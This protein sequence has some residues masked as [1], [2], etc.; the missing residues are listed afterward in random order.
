MIYPII[1]CGGTGARLWPLSRQ[2]HPK[3]FSKLIGDQ[4][5]FQQTCQRFARQGFANPVIVTNERF[6]FTVLDELAE[7]NIE[8]QDVILEAEA[9]NTAAAI[10]AAIFKIAEYDQ[11][12]QILIFASRSCDSRCG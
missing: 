1:L 12:A 11:N 6:R 2:T 10:L 5:L 8:A 4:S 3:Q 9:K 7:I